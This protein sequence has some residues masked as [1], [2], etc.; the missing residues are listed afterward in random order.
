MVAMAPMACRLQETC[1][2]P[3]P[4]SE[5]FSILGTDATALANCEPLGPRAL[6]QGLVA[7]QRHLLHERQRQ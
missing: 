5:G 1:T 3:K 7:F 6:G 4:R 2:M